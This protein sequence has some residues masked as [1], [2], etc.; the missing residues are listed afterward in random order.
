MLDLGDMK[1]DKSRKIIIQGIIM[2]IESNIIKDRMDIGS[3]S[4]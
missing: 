1:F 3:Q 4:I 2:H